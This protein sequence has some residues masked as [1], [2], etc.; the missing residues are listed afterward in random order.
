MYALEVSFLTSLLLRIA[1]IVSGESFIEVGVF[2]TTDST[3][4]SIS[5]ETT[6]EIHPSLNPKTVVANIPRESASA[7]PSISLSN[8]STIR[9]SGANSFFFVVNE[10]NELWI[11]NT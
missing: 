10:P 1:R 4:P 2:S 3:N 8:L 7:L 5:A 11:T 6:S 9:A